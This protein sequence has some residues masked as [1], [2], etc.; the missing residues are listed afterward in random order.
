M[1]PNLSFN[2]GL[3]YE[4][5]SP[6]HEKF[7]RMA[8]LDIAPGFTGV[9]VVTPGATGPY[10][11]AFPRGWWTRTATTSRRASA[12]PGGRTRSAVPGARRLRRLLQ[13]V[14]VQPGGQP[15]G[16][17]AAVRQDFVADHQHRAPAHDA[18][19]I[20][21]GA[22]RARSPTPTPST[23][24]TASATRRP[25]T[26]PCSRDLPPSIVVEV[27]LPGDQGNAAGRA[28][29]CRTARRRGRR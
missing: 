16:A 20:S 1:L 25:G 11:G 15:P 27:G 24:T 19:R 2:F 10:T 6:L 9:A 8:N 18:E 28:A 3:R 21:H 29:A 14:G 23:A 22:P 17:A 5:L 26:S 12:S 13:R 4:F 7:G